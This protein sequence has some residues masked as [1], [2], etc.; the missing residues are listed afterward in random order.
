LLRLAAV[1][2]STASRSVVTIDRAGTLPGRGAYLCR[3]DVAA[4]PRRECLLAATRRGGLRRALR[5]AVE[6]DRELADLG[7]LESTER[8]GAAGLQAGEPGP[9]SSIRS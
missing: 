9:S 8:V 4:I 1:A 5:A 3:A 7:S 2:Q 6:L